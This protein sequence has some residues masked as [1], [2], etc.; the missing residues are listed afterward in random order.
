MSME[1]EYRFLQQALLS[2]D[3]HLHIHINNRARE[4]QSVYDEAYKEGWIDRGDALT[5]PSLY[6]NEV[7]LKK[8]EEALYEFDKVL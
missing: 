3:K 1:L 2:H 4:L 5:T 7:S 6:T 8:A